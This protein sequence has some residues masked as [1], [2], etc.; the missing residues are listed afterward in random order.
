[1]HHLKNSYYTDG[2]NST[3]AGMIRYLFE[4]VPKYLLIDEIDKLDPKDQAFSLNLLETATV[5]ETKYGKTRTA[6]IKTSVAATSNNTEK[7]ST[8]LLSRFFIIYVIKLESY[9]YEQ[10]VT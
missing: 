3:K 5:T 4:N 7:L 6:Q 9:T 10:F 8:P 2:V 1:M